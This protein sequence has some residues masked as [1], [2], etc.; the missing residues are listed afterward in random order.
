M[1]AMKWVMNNTKLITENLSIAVEDPADLIRSTGV[2]D[3][4]AAAFY[5]YIFDNGLWLLS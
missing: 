3:D 1:P 4:M 2:L 5:W